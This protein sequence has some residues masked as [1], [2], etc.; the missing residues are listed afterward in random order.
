MMQMMYFSSNCGVNGGVEGLEALR[1]AAG[2][3]LA[4]KSTLAVG[5]IVRKPAWWR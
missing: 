1:I 3:A 4:I 2:A 5:T